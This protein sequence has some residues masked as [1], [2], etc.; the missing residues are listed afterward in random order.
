VTGTSTE[1]KP[2]DLTEAGRVLSAA[3]RTRIKS[4]IDSVHSACDSMQELLDKTDA[5]STTES[6]SNVAAIT[7]ALRAAQDQ[8]SVELRE[9]FSHDQQRELLANALSERAGAK[10]NWVW[11][12]DVYDDKVV[13]T[14]EPRESSPG[15][16][17]QLFQCSYSIDANSKVTLGDPAKV[18]QITD[19]VVVESAVAPPPDD[20][21]GGGAASPPP[22]PD[23][24]AEP[25]KTEPVVTESVGEVVTLG[26]D[27][28]PLTESSVRKDGTTLLKLIQPGWGSSGFYPKSVLER[29]GPLVFTEG[30][31]TFLDH[32]TKEEDKA[33]P[34]RSLHDLA[35]VLTSNARYMETGPDGPGLYADAKVF[36]AF[37]EV[38][39]ELAPHIGVSIRALG[40]AAPGEAEGR[41]GP[42]V[43]SIG[44]ARS[45][46]YVTQAGAGGRVM[47]LLESARV[48][49][50]EQPVERTASMPELELSEAA[51]QELATARAEANANANAL[52]ETRT[53]LQEAQ[54]QIKD[55]TPKVAASERMRERLLLREA[56]DLARIHLRTSDLPDVTIERL[57]R[58]A[59]NNPPIT[60]E[61]TIDEAKFSERL[62]ESVRSETAYIAKVTD[63][64]RVRGMG[65]GGS[66]PAAD[67][68]TSKSALSGSLQRLGLSE[69]ASKT[70]VNGRA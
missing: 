16:A 51:R 34:E 11:V 7:D 25:P 26:G 66:D 64:G 50:G 19:Y 21:A 37:R 46:D 14:V 54:A 22:A 18:K 1:Q 44:V 13:Y 17:G 49:T 3:S 38:V 57:I 63:S 20:G 43:E 5:T 60:E 35:G 53:Q 32:P 23:K 33:R 55:M 62:Q 9:V 52:Q 8:L 24:P 41:K 67:L 68:E 42:I 59:A 40:K 12:R 61:G 28:I 4:H 69:A 47:E 70:A 15:I 27:L 39:N 30:L 45:A 48:A 10:T 2:E 6:G 36:S 65:S 29:D 31:K 58:E 56:A